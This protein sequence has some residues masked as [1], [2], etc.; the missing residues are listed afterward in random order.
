MNASPY[1]K[2]IEQVRAALRAKRLDAL[3]V[4][5][6]PNVLYLSGFTGDSGYL[7]VEQDRTT[8]FTDGRFTVQARE[9][10]PQAKLVLQRGSLAATLGAYL[11]RE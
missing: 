5:H 1:A 4:T 6:L 7:L 3:L 2:R 8:L 11:A 10:A 9:E